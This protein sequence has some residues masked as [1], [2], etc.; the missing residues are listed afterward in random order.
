MTLDRVLV[1]E[2]LGRIQELKMKVR[3]RTEQGVEY[4]F[5]RSIDEAYTLMEQG[6][7]I[8]ALVNPALCGIRKK[9]D[10]SVYP[11]GIEL[12]KELTRS[13][14][15]VLY[16]EPRFED[17]TL[18]KS[19]VCVALVPGPFDSNDISN[20]MGF[21]ESGNLGNHEDTWY[22]PSGFPRYFEE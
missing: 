13:G 12:M 19:E 6:P 4:H 8:R 5:A 14:T 20:I 1:L 7:I 16:S 3:G 9:D 10:L 18:V 17:D 15:S 11:A 21:M 2:H 22:R